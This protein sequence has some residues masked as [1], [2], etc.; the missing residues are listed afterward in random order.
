MPPNLNLQSIKIKLK[1]DFNPTLNAYELKSKY[2]SKPKMR[3]HLRLAKL[4]DTNFVIGK[5]PKLI[6]PLFN[7]LK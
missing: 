2:K 3:Q 5:P 1:L 6:K 4:A 7:S